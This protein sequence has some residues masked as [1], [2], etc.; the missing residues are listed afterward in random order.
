MRPFDTYFF[1][2]HFNDIVEHSSEHFTALTKDQY[3][4]T[5]VKHVLALMFR[6][7]LFT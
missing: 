1:S 3:C 4:V 5:E 2:A 6:T 7:V